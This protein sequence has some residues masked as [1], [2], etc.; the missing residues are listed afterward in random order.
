MPAGAL[1]T[2]PA[3]VPTTVMVRSRVGWAATPK[4]AVA[5]ASNASTAKKQR[6]RDNQISGRV[7]NDDKVRLPVCRGYSDTMRLTGSIDDISGLTKY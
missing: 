3:P 2:V 4:G 7:F 6:L 5:A 1:V